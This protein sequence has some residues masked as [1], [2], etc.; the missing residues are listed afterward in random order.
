MLTSSLTQAITLTANPPPC[1][2]ANPVPTENWSGRRDL[3]PRPPAREAGAL[4]LS[5]AR[6][7]RPRFIMS[8]SLRP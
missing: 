6:S 4:P 5:Y 2:F 3:N 8:Q 1:E 7:L